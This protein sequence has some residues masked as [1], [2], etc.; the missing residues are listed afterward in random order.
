MKALVKLLETL[1]NHPPETFPHDVGTARYEARDELDQINA[2]AESARNDPADS[3]GGLYRLA[4]ILERHGI[5]RPEEDHLRPIAEEI[6][7]LRQWP[8]VIAHCDEHIAELKRQRDEM[9]RQR[10]SAWQQLDEAWGR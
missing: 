10:N 1:E 8:A 2:D 7:Y 3:V 5:S 6:I 4:D 9:E